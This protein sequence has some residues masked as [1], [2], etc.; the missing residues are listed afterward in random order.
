V[1]PAGVRLLAPAHPEGQ[2]EALV[3]DPAFRGRGYDHALLSDGAHLVGVHDE[4]R[5][6]RGSSVSVQLRPAGCLL[7][8]ADRAAEVGIDAITMVR[9]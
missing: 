6:E 1:R 4:R 5:W 7:F 8:A 2:L 9:V 3:L